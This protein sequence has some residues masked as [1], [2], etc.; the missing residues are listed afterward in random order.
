MTSGFDVLVQ[1]VIAAMATDPCCT[2]LAPGYL[3]LDPPELSVLDGQL[4]DRASIRVDESDRSLGGAGR[5]AVLPRGARNLGSART[6]LRREGDAHTFGDLGQIDA[7][8][9]PT[10]ASQARLD[11]SQIQL[12]QV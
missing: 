2:K 12:Q 11:R 3:D 6:K 1:L 5:A 7:I 9:R 10:R 8:L 4:G